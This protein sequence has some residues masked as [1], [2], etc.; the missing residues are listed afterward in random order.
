MSHDAPPPSASFP[1]APPAGSPI[2][3]LELMLW[4]DG[5]LEPRRAAE[6]A[7]LVQR[8]ARSRAIVA[9]LRLGGSLVESDA[10]R[11]A[12]Q[13]GADSIVDAVMDNIETDSTRRFM[14]RPRKISQVRGPAM[15][16]AAFALAAAAVWALF[17]RTGGTESDLA[18]RTVP[19]P[20]ESSASA[21]V[22]GARTASIEV[23]D[24]GARPGTIFYVP[25]E[26]D[27]AMAVVWLTDDDASGESQ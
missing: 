21:S 3:D 8:D 22:G 24:F 23:V 14:S 27:S 17:F 16:A 11:R 6:V 9:G 2:T 7:A 19:A 20:S 5:E 1:I 13:H 26:G 18:T 10:Q 25:S 12:S 4:L 15:T